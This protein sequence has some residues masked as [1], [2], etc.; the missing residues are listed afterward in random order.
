MKLHKA[1]KLRKKL[2][3][4]IARL[5][6]QIQ[7]KNSYLVGSLNATKFDV[8]EIYVNL[9][10]KIDE[11]VSLK[12]VINEANHEIQAKIYILS[13]YKA[14]IA[15]WNETSVQEGIQ[16][17]GY[18]EAITREYKVQIDEETRN[19]IVEQF[20]I[21]V[22]ALQEEIDTFNYTTDIPWD[23]PI[24]KKPEKTIKADDPAK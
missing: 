19:K 9:L 7:S 1:L 5:K 6:E 8:N 24:A 23:E 18:S 10:N 15:F 11:L 16:T 4:E 3:G 14:L 13:E 21:K 2:T 17:I 22:D 12:Y 20:Q